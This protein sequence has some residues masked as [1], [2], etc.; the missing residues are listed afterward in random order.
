MVPLPKLVQGL[1]RDSS[2]QATSEDAHKREEGKRC[3]ERQTASR[4]RE[5]SKQQRSPGYV[6]GSLYRI[7]KT[8]TE[9]AAQTT[10]KP[11]L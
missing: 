9:A 5:D 2:V 4:Y 3:K 6:S 1:G 7:H 10:G 8:W 11:S